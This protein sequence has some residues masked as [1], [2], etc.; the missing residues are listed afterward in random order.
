MLR[1]IRNNLSIFL[2]L[3]LTSCAT[4]T[5]TTPTTPQPSW[6]ERKLALS[7][8]QNWQIKGKIAVQT[9]QDAGSA[10]I[11]WQQYADRYTVSLWGPLGTHN[12][13]LTGQPGSIVLETADGKKYSANSPE[14]LLREQWG[15]NVPISY[16][17]YWIRGLPA[18]GAATLQFDASNRL[19]HL[20]QQDWQVVFS[21]YTHKG[22]IDLPERMMITSAT[23][24]TKIIIYRWEI[25]LS[26]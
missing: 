2:I 6:T 4:V 20:T 22:K 21:G 16:L 10:N 1:L 15:F 23:L 18:P 3:T 8:I 26:H 24:R 7:R 19:S 14:Q 13:K 17:R 5:P 25:D 9:A 12:V 11:A